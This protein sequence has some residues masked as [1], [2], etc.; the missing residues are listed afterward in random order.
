V[1]SR[2]LPARKLRSRPDLDQLRRQ[3]RELRDAFAAGEPAAASEVT[4]HLRAADPGSFALH[5]AQFVLA[6]SYGFDSWPKLKARVDGVTV[7]RL[8]EALDGGDEPAAR[9]ILR[10]RPELVHCEWPDHGEVRPLHVAVMRR[11]PAMVGL[12]MGLGA[13]ARIGIYP[14]RDAT[15]AITMALER[16]YD[17]IVAVIREAERDRA[18]AAAPAPGIDGVPDERCNG[19]GSAQASAGTT[20]GDNAHA[21]SLSA[22]AAGDLAQIRALHAEGRLT[23]ATTLGLFKPFGGLLTAAVEHDRADVLEL[24]LDCG[25]DPDER[26]RIEGSDD[27]LYSWGLPLYTCVMEGKPGMA[28]LL[29]ERGADPNAQILAS[30]TPTYAAYRRKDAGMIALLEE[31]GGAL[32]AASVGYLRLT[33]RARKMLAGEAD[34]RLEYGTFSG[35]TVAEQILW[36][37]ASGCEPEIVRMALER[38]DWARDDSRWFSMLWRPLPG[39]H[40]RELDEQ[41]RCRECFRLILERCDPDVRS[42]F[43]QTMLHEVVARDHGEGAALATL[44]LDAGARLTV[45]DHLLCS[46]PLGWACRW[47]RRELVKLFLERGADPIEQDAEPWATPRAWAGKRGNR[48]VLDLLDHL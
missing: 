24:L 6:R 36:S 34:P 10:H 17:E 37:G 43:G 4:A 8:C 16:G 26:V 46:T 42:P 9:E 7:D 21:A 41:A 35:E 12:L 15:S 22:V 40:V 13:D 20:P 33:D 30:G 32:D 25:L 44:L 48:D 39:H 2:S 19:R 1:P 28:R 14:N 11:N 38:I 5:D 3:A 23:T 47:G 45:R 29:L 27:V 31:R 18:G